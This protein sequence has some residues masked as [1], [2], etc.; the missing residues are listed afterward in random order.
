MIFNLFAKIPEESAK[1]KPVKSSKELTPTEIICYPT[2]W[3]IEVHF[4]KD[5]Y[6]AYT[7]DPGMK[8]T[9]NKLLEWFHKETTPTFHLHH[10]KGSDILSRQNIQYITLAK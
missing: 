10:N 1:E 8:N 9:F 5:M 6:E 2:K 4:I 7:T 3:I